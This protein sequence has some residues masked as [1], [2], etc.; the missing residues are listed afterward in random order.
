LNGSAPEVLFFS[1]GASFSG[2][3]LVLIFLSSLAIIIFPVMAAHLQE[4]AVV[5][6]LLADEDRLHRRLHVVVDAAP[7]A[8][9]ARD[10]AL[11][12]IGGSGRVIGRKLIAT[13]R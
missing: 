4:A 2:A 7:E 6:A 11:R 9:T 12:L 1:G 3:E 10:F 8:A 5:E 13:I